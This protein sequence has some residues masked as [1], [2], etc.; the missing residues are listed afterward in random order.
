[1]YDKEQSGTAVPALAWQSTAVA[2]LKKQKVLIW[3]R[4]SHLAD[5]MV[6][7]IGSISVCKHR[8]REENGVYTHK[9]S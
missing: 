2:C 3:Q 7:P 1:M 6:A 4:G 8:A 5:L 9:T